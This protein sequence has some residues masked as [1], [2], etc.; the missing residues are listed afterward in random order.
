MTDQTPM[1]D[2]R[3]LEI[4]D[5]VIQR[6]GHIVGS[7]VLDARDYLTTRLRAGGEAVAWQYLGT[8]SL[9]PFPYPE[10]KPCDDP[11]RAQQN[12][13]EVRPLYAAPPRAPVAEGVC[14]TCNGHGM[15]GGPS[16][17]EPD[18]GGVPCPDCAVPPER[19]AEV[20]VVDDAMVE[21]ARNAYNVHAYVDGWYSPTSAMRAA[22][23]A[24]LSRPAAE[25]KP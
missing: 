24:A 20:P 7:D 2:E 14:A 10:W 22:L 12:G 9:G 17:R 13:Y 21:R 3:V 1:T 18:E 6:S 11:E 15:I 8:S 19:A 25:V 5:S 16:F 4:L 23:T